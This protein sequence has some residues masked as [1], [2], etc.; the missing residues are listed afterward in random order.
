MIYVCIHFREQGT[1]TE[2]PS[3]VLRNSAVEPEWQ[4]GSIWVKAFAQVSSASN[5][6]EDLDM[7]KRKERSFQAGEKSF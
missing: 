4:R 5:N 7:G 6:K 3:D 2:R 1:E